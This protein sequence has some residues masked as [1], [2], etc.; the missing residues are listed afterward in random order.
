VVE[1]GV[2]HRVGLRR[3]ALEPV[4]IRESAAMNVGTC[5]G[6]R[7]RTLFRPGEAHYV[8]ARGNQVRYN[9]RSDP[10]GSSSNKYSHSKISRFT[11]QTN[12]YHSYIL[13]K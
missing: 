5:C 8:M 11:L 7:L 4:E 6:K 3:A 10:T 12:L 9:G 2:D 13:V 1:G